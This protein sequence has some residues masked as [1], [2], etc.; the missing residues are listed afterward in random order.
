[1]L[2]EIIDHAYKKFLDGREV[3]L[4][5]KRG[6][7]LYRQRT[8]AMHERQKGI[9]PMCKNPMS[10]EIG[11]ENSATF[12]HVDG[13]GMGG[14]HRDDRI[15]DENG[16]PM[17]QA[18]CARDNYAKGSKRVGAKPGRWENEAGSRTSD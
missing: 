15:V 4:T 3:C 1:M 8:L 18:L 5:N 14:G 11:F 13:R 2:T 9:C 6:L 7:K 10:T 16:K 12:D 17:N